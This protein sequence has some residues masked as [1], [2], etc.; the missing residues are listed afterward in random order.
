MP[1]K[2]IKDGFRAMQ[3]SEFDVDL[4]MVRR[5]RGIEPDKGKR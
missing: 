4:S 5:P 3:T 2:R 1:Q